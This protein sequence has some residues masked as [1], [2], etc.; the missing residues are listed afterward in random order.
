[1]ANP[2]VDIGQLTPTQ[3]EALQQYTAVTN[4]DVAA[5]IPL[6]QRS[7]WNVQI[8][9][10]KFFDG[11]GPDPVAEALSS[12]ASIPRPSR[13]ENL[14]E[15]LLHGSHSSPNGTRQRL[16]PAP[17]VVPQPEDQQVAPR[18]PFLLALLF[19]PFSLL[20]KIFS[21]SFSL[22][23]YL[24]PFLP[25]L[26]GPATTGR[27]SITSRRP[28]KPRD[29]AARL[30]R[31]LEEEYGPAMSTLPL[32]EGS[33]ASALDL[34]KR[35]L[36]FL[37]VL[38]LS[39][40]HDDTAPF[41]RSVL[42]SDQLA[43][44]LDTP[45]NKTNLIIW[46]GDV[47]DSEAYQVSTAL[48]CTKFPFSALITHTPSQGSTSMSV[49]ARLTGPVPVGTYVAKLQAAISTHEAQL[50][51]VRAERSA[52]QAERNIRQEQ[53]SAYERSLAQDR[54]RARLRREAEAKA[55]EEE[56]KRKEA[57]EAAA[58]LAAKRAQW[59]RWRASKIA[60]EPSPSASNVVRIAL[61]MPEAARIMRR[62]DGGADIE[63][64]YAF[65]E[66]YDIVTGGETEAES[67]DVTKPEGYEHSF[68]FQLVSTLPRVVYDVASGGTILERVG[69]T[70]NLIVES[71]VD[72]DEDED[73]EDE[74]GDE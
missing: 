25:R 69:K 59:R 19:T 47:R 57:E 33:Y 42:L 8:A 22:F 67:S 16:D 44:F 58:I 29:S 10:A 43:T 62:F 37:L 72:E 60:S 14:H 68:E 30:K 13:T 11:E 21:G 23:T 50:V 70:G 54:E 61:K 49:V 39:P 41:I 28:L 15:S 46:A 65:V 64:L 56:K 71:I 20:Y 6:L 1:M 66:C 63:E 51:T 55:A 9:I 18:P 34:A 53:D 36:K 48:R 38:L 40:E 24:F 12:Q 27:S 52:Q 3:Q 7:Q 17:R 74:K 5:A 2:Q 31:E 73:E 35:E 26:L 32:Y 45:Q 4:Q